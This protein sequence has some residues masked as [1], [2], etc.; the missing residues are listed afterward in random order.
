ML[1]IIRVLRAACG[2]CGGTGF[3]I[4][5]GQTRQCVSCNGSG[6]R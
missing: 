3:V 4:I 2:S 1:R 5:D 6:S